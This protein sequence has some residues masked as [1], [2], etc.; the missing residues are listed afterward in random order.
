M[1][2]DYY[3][4]LNEKMDA[5]SRN[6]RDTYSRMSFLI[7]RFKVVETLITGN[8]KPDRGIVVRL[9]RAEQT[10]KTTKHF[11]WI[12]VSAYVAGLV[13]YYIF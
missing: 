11:L 12:L 13:G 3:T 10:L 5:V 2:P 8:G 1:G 7:E 6:T 4:K 9:D